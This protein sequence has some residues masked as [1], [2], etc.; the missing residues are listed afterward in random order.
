MDTET[1]NEYLFAALLSEWAGA[2]K[3]ERIRR[4]GKH[5]DREAGSA[6]TTEEDL[7]EGFRRLHARRHVAL[8]LLQDAGKEP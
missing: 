1:L 6:Q 3:M 7:R 5:T 8:A 2:A 4:E